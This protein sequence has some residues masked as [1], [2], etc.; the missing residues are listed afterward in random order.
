MKIFVNPKVGELTIPS[1][2]FALHNFGS[3][4]CV[5]GIFM[6]YENSGVYPLWKK[7]IEDT[8]K[9]IPN[10]PIFGLIPTN[11]YHTDEII[12][13]GRELAE[14]KGNF[15]PSVS[16]PLTWQGLNACNKLISEGIDVCIG[17]CETVSQ[18]VLAARAN[19]TYI[20]LFNYEK[21]NPNNTENMNLIREIREGFKNYPELNSQILATSIKDNEL[22]NLAFS[23]GA[24]AVS[25]SCDLWSSLIQ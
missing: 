22:L 25:I 7:F 20:G 13:V 15:Y 14:I 5:D 9:Q 11:C 21:Y 8:C 23:Y 3:L 18:A 4:S 17:P 1:E 24:D 16:L 10:R 2:T 6:S 19:A 12:N